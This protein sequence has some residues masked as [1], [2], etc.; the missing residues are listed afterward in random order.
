MYTLTK[1]AHKAGPGR[2]AFTI[3]IFDPIPPQYYVTASSETWLDSE[4]THEVSKA[5]NT[6]HRCV[7]VS[8]AVMTWFV[9]F[10]SGS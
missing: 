1:K 8:G 9:S 2:V 7:E 4:T 6:V 3:P 10:L 5:H